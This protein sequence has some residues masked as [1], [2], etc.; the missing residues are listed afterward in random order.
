MGFFSLRYFRIPGANVPSRERSIPG[1]K[2]RGAFAPGNF[3]S[4][5]ENDKRT[6]SPPYF[7][8]PVEKENVLNFSTLIII[9]HGW[10][11]G[12]NIVQ[13]VKP[14]SPGFLALHL[15]L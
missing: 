5:S 11:H 7:S 10:L 3:R 12:L 14:R 8:L 9:T 15:T 1:A 2:T 13:H 6:F 4:Q